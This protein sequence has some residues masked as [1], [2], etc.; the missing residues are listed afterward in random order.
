MAWGGAF[1]CPYPLTAR[2]WVSVP[3]W[4]SAFYLPACLCT[5]QDAGPLPVCGSS[6]APLPTHLRVLWCRTCEQRLQTQHG[7]LQRQRRAP[8]IL[9]DVQADGACLAADVGVPDLQCARGDRLHTV[10]GACRM[11]G[12]PMLHGGAES[13]ARR[14]RKVRPNAA[15]SPWKIV[16][17]SP[18]AGWNNGS[19]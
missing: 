14:M 15:C 1:A 2:G 3:Y 10:R 13:C 8:L 4:M 6:G 9:Q 5:E 7:G 16:P 17:P 18:Q 12:G 11:R 19:K